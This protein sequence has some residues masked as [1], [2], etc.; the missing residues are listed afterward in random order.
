[1]DDTSSRSG[2]TK[3]DLDNYHTWTVQVKCWLVT[4]GLFKWTQ[5]SPAA[6]EEGEAVPAADQ[7]SDATALAYIGMTLTEQHLPTFSECETAKDA[8]DAFAKL[9]KSKSKARRMQLK[10]EMSSLAKQP[11]EPLVKYFSRAKHLKSQLLS[12]GTTVPDDELALSVLNGLPAEYQTLRTVL[13]A[14]DDDMSLDE[15]MPKLLVVENEDSKPVPESK[16]F[17][18][19]PGMGHA[20]KGRT[21]ASGKSP[22]ETR[23]CHFCGK[24]G[25]L[26]KDCWKRQREEQGAGSSQGQ[27][28]S[29]D[30]GRGAQ[31]N[32]ACAAI[33]TNMGEAW[34]LDSGASRHI[35]MSRAGM[36]N[37]RPVSADTSITFGNGSK[38]SVEAVEDVVL[39]IPDSD[40]LE[41]QATLSSSHQQSHSA[42]VQTSLSC[43]LFFKAALS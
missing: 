30:H 40:V 11:G 33:R 32:V 26:K 14:S 38:A 17:V 2:I 20:N 15:L 37:L 18:A 19:R 9:F 43:S 13:T 39:R 10:S 29:R 34:V 16:A 42:R 25:H 28:S 7:E 24:P 6:G 23:K 1:M 8:W 36:S 21:G 12:V 41:K 5:A 31:G 35:A 22:K 3:L 27:R 4:K